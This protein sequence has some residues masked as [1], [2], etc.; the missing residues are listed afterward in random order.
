MPS[1]VIAGAALVIAAAFGWAAWAKALYWGS[2]RLALTTYGLPERLRPAVAGAVPAIEL[3]IVALM[4][5]GQVLVGAAVTVFLLAA[6]SMAVLRAASLSRSTRVPCGCFGRSKERDYRFLLVRNAILGALAAVV[7]VGDRAF[8]LLRGLGGPSRTA[9]PV[10]LVLAAIIAVCLHSGRRA[11][12][13]LRKRAETS[14]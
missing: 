9:V 14:P 13:T 3:V 8:D 1:S 10:V 11:A 4:L 6:F 7:L 12:M 5:G 2:W